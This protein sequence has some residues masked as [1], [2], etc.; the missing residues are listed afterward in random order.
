MT[1]QIYPSARFCYYNFKQGAGDVMIDWVE[2]REHAGGGSV[3]GLMELRV[4]DLIDSM[5][6]EMN[7]MFWSDI[8]GNDGMDF[9]GIQLLIST[10]IESISC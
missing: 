3:I 10:G 7:K 1:P 5:R 8:V 4:Q 2:E 6:E 9:N